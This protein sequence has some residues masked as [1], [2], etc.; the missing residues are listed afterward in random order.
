MSSRTLVLRPPPG[1]DVQAPW[2]AGTSLSVDTP[3]RG[4][5]WVGS[6]DP[7]AQALPPLQEFHDYRDYLLAYY[8]WKRSI[9]HRFSYRMLASRWLL[10][11][12]FVYRVLHRKNHLALSAVDRVA[13]AIGLDADGS[14]Y[15]A[16]LVQQGRLA[17]EPGRNGVRTDAGNRIGQLAPQ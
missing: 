16:Q 17:S 4:G 3:L 6:P 2:H 11:V 8:S 7:S 12:S 13:R 15:F 14:R 9:N 10:D 5:A 1:A